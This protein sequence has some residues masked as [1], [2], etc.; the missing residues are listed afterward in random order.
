M[1]KIPY[2]KLDH[3]ISTGKSGKGNNK[4]N[5]FN[6]FSE[7][8]DLRNHMRNNEPK[9]KRKNTKAQK[10]RVIKQDVVPRGIIHCN[11]THIFTPDAGWITINRKLGLNKVQSMYPTVRE[12]AY[13]LHEDGE[14]ITWE[15]C[16]YKYV[17]GKAIEYRRSR[18]RVYAN[19]K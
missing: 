1:S 15:D 4:R 18:G 13:S 17:D 5:A 8:I 2:E 7:L 3:V 9:Q 11:T 10:P 12:V 16:F 14:L 19:T 6:D